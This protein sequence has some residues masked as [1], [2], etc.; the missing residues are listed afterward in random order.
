VTNLPAVSFSLAGS[1]P[2]LGSSL[3]RVVGALLL[4]LALFFAGIWLFKNWRRFLQQ[5]GRAPRL[6]ILEV[7]SLGQRQ[8]VYV[9]GYDQQRFL[10]ASSPAGVTLLTHLPT[11]DQSQAD[12]VDD[13]INF[14]AVLQ[15]TLGRQ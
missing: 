14:A 4:V 12:P 15:E 10:L 3:L 9:V 5:K 7:K 1:T 8:A 6:N 13:T 11:A 2:E